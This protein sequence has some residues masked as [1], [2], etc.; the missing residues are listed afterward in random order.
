MIELPLFPLN[1]V[2]LPGTP[3]GL[4]VFEDRYREM[5]NRCLRTSQLFG[6]VLIRRGREAASPLAEPCSVGCT[7]QILQV[8]TMVEGRMNIMA[9]GRERFRIHALDYGHPY[10]VGAVEL[11]E[12]QPNDPGDLSAAGDR[13]RPLVARYLDT[14]SEISEAVLDPADLPADPL[15]LAYLAAYLVQLPPARKQ[16]LLAQD[17]A[18]ALLADV[19]KIYQQEVPL[20]ETMVAEPHVQRHGPF[21]L[22]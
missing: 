21:S 22:N 1:T 6:V 10:L 5:M 18:R 14:L 8:Q 13:L 7:A 12:M 17:D 4:H 16:G 9:V 3:L 11:L 2:L 20:L 19:E 15:S